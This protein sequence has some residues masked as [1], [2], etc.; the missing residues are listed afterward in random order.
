MGVKHQGLRM[1][2]LSAFHSQS[3]EI[4]KLKQEAIKDKK[5]LRKSSCPSK[6]IPSY[7]TSVLPTQV[8]KDDFIV[9][10][11]RQSHDRRPSQRMLSLGPPQRLN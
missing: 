9:I 4:R 11:V 6:E 3:K 8:Q 5:C 1:K 10:P 2:S 7:L